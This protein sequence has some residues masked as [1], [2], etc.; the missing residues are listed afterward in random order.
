M[1]VKS[2][3]ARAIASSSELDVSRTAALSPCAPIL[4][5]LWLAPGKID[6][7]QSKLHYPHW[8]LVDQEPAFL[9]RVHHQDLTRVGQDR[10]AEPAG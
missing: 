7:K 9:Q 5:P 10:G 8:S 4:S 6:R 3:T 1:F 2:N